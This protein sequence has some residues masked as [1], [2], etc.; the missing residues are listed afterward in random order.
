M[1]VILVFVGLVSGFGCCLGWAGTSAGLFGCVDFLVR[2]ILCGW[3]DAGLRVCGGWLF[4]IFWL[5]LFVLIL[6]VLGFSWIRFDLAVGVLRCFLVF[7]VW[8]LYGIGGLGL[9]GVFPGLGLGFGLLGSYLLDF[10]L[11][12]V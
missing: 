10:D 7:L 1:G 4:G 9:C 12:L 8:V 3:N 2:S 5:G 6:V 11:W